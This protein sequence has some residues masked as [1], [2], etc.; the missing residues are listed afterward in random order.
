MCEA[1]PGM[2]AFTGSDST[3]AFVGKGKKQAFQVVVSDVDMCNA[4]R[5]IG[6]S[7]HIADEMLQACGQFVCSLYGYSGNNTDLVCYKLFCTKNGQAC[8]LPLIQDA[9]KYNVMRA[10]Y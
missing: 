4:M 2:H 5:L 3:S 1:L 10:N 8:H 7:F 6:S 9:L